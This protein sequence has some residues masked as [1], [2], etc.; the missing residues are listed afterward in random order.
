[1]FTRKFLPILSLILTVTAGSTVFAAKPDPKDPPTVSS[2]TVTDIGATT[3]TLGGTV[4]SDGGQALTERG[5][6]WSTSSPADS[7]GTVVIEGGTAVSAFTVP[8]TGLPQGTLIYF[9]AYAINARG[10]SYSAESSFTTISSAGPP[11]VDTSTLASLVAVTSSSATLGGFISKWNVTHRKCFGGRR[12][13]HRQFLA[14]ALRPEFGCTD[15]FSLL[16]G[17]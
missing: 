2:P 1:M 12:Y 3:A 13:N 11:V 16:C 9:K 8:V 4:D 10:T 17:Q 15:L 5:V 14:F 6:V 7:G